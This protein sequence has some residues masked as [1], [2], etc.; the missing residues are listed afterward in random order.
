M[1]S[2]MK[3]LCAV[4]VLLLLILGCAS[5]QP[6]PPVNRD[7]V[8]PGSVVQR[9]DKRFPLLG[10]PISIGDSLPSVSLMDAMTMKEVDLS[11]ERGKVLFLNMVPSLDTPV[12]D[13]QTHYLGEEGDKLPDLVERITVSRDTPFAQK[14]FAEEAKLT[15]LRYLSDY[16]EGDFG[17]SVGLL[18]DGLRLLA[19]SVILVD[20][21]G[22]VRYIQVVPEITHMPDMEAAFLKATQLAKEK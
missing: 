5:L 19:R 20:T 3:S 11:Q 17:R 7:S 9:G 1:D 21:R 2:R 18:M 4:G 10:T 14:R 6:K 12:C 8:K 13:A 15:D 16:R 22:K